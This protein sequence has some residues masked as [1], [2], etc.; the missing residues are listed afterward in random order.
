MWAAMLGKACP[1]WHFLGMVRHD[2]WRHHLNIGGCV[3]QLPTIELDDQQGL[4]Q[5]QH[6]KYQEVDRE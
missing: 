6:S 1:A 3:G 5:S 4:V 2:T